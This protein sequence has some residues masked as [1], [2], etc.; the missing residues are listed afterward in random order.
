[1]RDYSKSAACSTRHVFSEELQKHTGGQGTQSW[2][3]SEM[4]QWLVFLHMYNLQ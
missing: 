4:M 2:H 3:A 1:M